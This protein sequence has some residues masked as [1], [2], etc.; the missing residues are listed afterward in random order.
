M[1]FDYTEK[2]F[3]DLIRRNENNK[4]VPKNRSGYDAGLN[5]W[6]LHKDP[7]RG[8]NV[9]YGHQVSEAEIAAGI[10]NFGGK[11]YRL[12]DG[13]PD[14]VVEKM[15]LSDIEK[16]Y[17]RAKEDFNRLK[18]GGLTWSMVPDVTQA[19]MAIAAYTVGGLGSNGNRNRNKFGWPN[20]LGA[21]LVGDTSL[22][23]KELDRTST[24]ESRIKDEAAYLKA[25]QERPMAGKSRLTSAEWAAAAGTPLPKLYG[26]GTPL[27]KSGDLSSYVNAYRSSVTRS[28]HILQMQAVEA[29]IASLKA[30][31]AMM[32][33][34]PK[35]PAKPAEEA[36]EKLSP[37]TYARP[38]GAIISV[39]T[40]G[41]IEEIISGEAGKAL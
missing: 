17:I 3:V 41:K 25:Y 40:D 6:F 21:T 20:L 11:K 7:G 34:E 8:S 26:K 10:M 37:G 1:A 36:P 19:G 31:G 9:G 4:N 35:A 32:P 27:P 30:A 23:E 24:A 14:D 29:G 12:A 5:R 28:G 15:L 33:P 18:P 22:Y 13:V 39:G 2:E 16:H 38:N